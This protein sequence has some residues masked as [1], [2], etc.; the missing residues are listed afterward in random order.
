[1]KTKISK[2]F[3]KYQFKIPKSSSSTLKVPSTPRIARTP[4]II[5]TNPVSKAKNFTF[6]Y[7]IG[8][9]S[10]GTVWKATSLLD[11]K[12]YAIKISIK[13]QNISNLI[14]RVEKLED[15]PNIV[16]TIDIWEEAR[17]QYTQMELCERG[18]LVNVLDHLVEKNKTLDNDVLW[19][20]IHDISQGLL[21][22]H[23]TIGYHLDI[24]P[25]NLL[26]GDNGNIKICDFGPVDGEGD[27]AYMARELLNSKT[28]LF[29][30][31]FSFGISL[32]EMV[33]NYS[34]PKSGEWW[35]DLRNGIIEF[36][37]DIY[38]DTKPTLPQVSNSLK[39][40]IIQMMNPDPLQRISTEDILKK[41]SDE[42]TLDTDIDPFMSIFDSMEITKPSILDN[43][44]KTKMLPHLQIDD[45]VNNST[46]FQCNFQKLL[47]QSCSFPTY[48]NTLPTTILGNDISFPS[49]RK[50]NFI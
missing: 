40:L 49:K 14:N 25:E 50:L 16:K 22:I 29:A 26:V 33:T 36:P 6:H 38:I 17:Y 20:I 30:D 37:Q 41:I 27:N 44:I 35:H 32:F 18:S 9:G 7:V 12:N 5:N 3:N 15:H 19:R 34:L 23:Q 1:M 2:E 11:K 48:D 10:F 42:I 47:F 28:T 24:K 4:K 13:S 39:N 21:H 8:Q 45:K 31:I 46:I 43:R